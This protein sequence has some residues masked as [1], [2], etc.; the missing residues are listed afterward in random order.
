MLFFISDAS[1]KLNVDLKFALPG[2]ERQDSVFSGFQVYTDLVL[3]FGFRST[4]S[5]FYLFT[6]II[7][8]K[9]SV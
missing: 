5:S 6:V 3:S 4:E 7:L 8:L 9:Y 2:K 1:E